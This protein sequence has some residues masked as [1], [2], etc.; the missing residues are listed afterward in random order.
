MIRVLQVVGKLG[1][2]GAETRLIELAGVV[3]KSK[4]Y[5]DFC[6]FEDGD[7]DEQARKLGCGIV[8]CK[9]T[10]NIFSFSRGFRELLRQGQY[11]VIHCHIYQFSGVPLR[12]AAREGIAKRI[13]HL[14]T[15]KGVDQNNPYRFCYNKLMTAWIKRYST[16]IV[17][18]SQAAMESFMGPQ[19]KND[20][21]TSIIYNGINI[22][23]FLR[24]PNRAETLTEFD[25]PYS[26][27][28]VIHVGNFRP[29]KDHKTLIKTAATMISRNKAVHFLLVGCGPLMSDI[30]KLVLA[31]GL[32]KNVHFAGPRTD[33]P[34]L[35][36]SSDC[37]LFPSKW[38]G[39]GGA[40]LE[41][42]AA[43]L[44]V[45]ASDIPA[46]REIASQ[47]DNVHLVPAGDASG[48][49]QKLQEILADLQGYRK[50]PGQVPERFRFENYIDKMLSLYNQA[51]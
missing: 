45:V 5:F 39:L 6:V 46:I 40:V 15:T 49:A 26:A 51:D 23:P 25:I 48:F 17:A 18:I 42:L 33:V 29:P 9:L 37:F 14:R 16:K 38:E 24:L 2:G 4:F 19:W 34:R 43:G 32:E 11:D 22:E 27:Q 47:S 8:K 3:D 36:M 20:S 13:V 10:R 41:A 12:I 30:R 1:L 21:R 50:K 28:V 44:P 7:Y 31:G 35:L